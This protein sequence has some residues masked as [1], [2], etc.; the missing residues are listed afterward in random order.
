MNLN[1]KYNKST[2]EI[3]IEN[4][5]EFHDQLYRAREKFH[6]FLGIV[7]S[8]YLFPFHLKY[9]VYHLKQWAEKIVIFYCV[10]CAISIEP[11][12]Y[13]ARYMTTSE[14]KYDLKRGAKC[15]A[16]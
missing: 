3:I 10:R 9:F 16:Q 2:N 12:Y 8:S 13:N 5:Y 1:K 11:P 7:K 15:V 4:S 6:C 14:A